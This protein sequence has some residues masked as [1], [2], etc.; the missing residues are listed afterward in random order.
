VHGKV[1]EYDIAPNLPTAAVDRISICEVVNN[2]LDNA[3]KYSPDQ[4][5]IVVRSLLNKDG[6]IET[7]IQD[8]G[9]GIPE[10]VLPNL[11]EKFYRNHRTRG[12]IGGTGLGLYLSKALVT[13]HG[14]HIWANS[15]EG[16][17]SSF[18]FTVMPYSQLAEEQKDGANTDIVRQAHGWIKNHSYYRR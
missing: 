13:A 7:V 2:L 17:G 5:R 12:Q 6:L 18:G 14:G 8:F 10:S 11:F 16:E 15:K 1:I 4:K 3:I 9:I